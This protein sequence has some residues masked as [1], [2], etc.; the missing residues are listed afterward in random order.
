MI[1]L[2]LSIVL[3]IVFSFKSAFGQ[4]FIFAKK[5]VG[6]E[7]IISIHDISVNQKGEVAYVGTFNGT[8]DFDPSSSVYSLSSAGQEDMFFLKFDSLGDFSWAKRIG[9]TSYE[10]GTAIH[11]DNSDNIIT[12]GSFTGVVDFDPGSNVVNK[13]SSG[14]HDG[15]IS[16]YNKNGE[17]L[18]NRQLSSYNAQAAIHEIA[19]DYQNNVYIVGSYVDK[20]Y[21]GPN[22]NSDSLV[23]SGSEDVFFFKLDS[24]GNYL[25]KK[26][27]GGPYSDLAYSLEA[28][29]FNNIYLSGYFQFNCDFD[30]DTSVAVLYGGARTAYI[31]KYSSDGD[32]IWAKAIGS[33]GNNEIYSSK[34][35]PSGHIYSTGYFTG[36]QD[37]NPGVGV[38]ILSSNGQNDVFVLKL[39]TNG[40]FVWARKVGGSNYDLAN[41]LAIDSMENLFV[42]GR[43]KG[44]VD[45]DPDTSFYNLS[46]NGSNHAYTF[47]LDSAGF[48]KW[49]INTGGVYNSNG[50]SIDTD[51]KG[52]V[53]IHGYF[54]GDVDFDSGPDSTI[55]S[56]SSYSPFLLKLRQTTCL[57]PDFN[58]YYN[59]CDSFYWSQLDTTYYT[60]GIY[61]DTM[62]NIN[63]CDSVILL[64]LNIR[65]NYS[66]DT[67]FACNSYTWINGV[68]YFSN[69][70]VS[71]HTMQNIF[72]CDSTVFLN[73]TISNS[74][75]VVDSI[76]ACDSY[77]WIDGNTYY[78]NNTTAIDTLQTVNGCDS[79]V[80]LHLTINNSKS[81]TDSIIACDSYTWIDGNTYTSNNSTATHTLSAINGCDS[82]ISLDLTIHH[83]N[84]G[85]DAIT[86]CNSYTWIDG[87]TYTASSNLPTYTLT[88]SNGC[89]SVV[90]LQL[91]IENISDTSTSIVGATIS[92]NNT[93]ASYQWLNCDNSFSKIIGETGQSF[94]PTINGNYAVELTENTCI[95]TTTCV[96]INN[97]GIG[98]NASN[99]EVCIFPNPSSGSVT[100]NFDEKCNFDIKVYDLLGECIYQ[101]ANLF[102]K[103]YSFNL[104]VESGMYII[105]LSTKGKKIL[106]N[107][108]INK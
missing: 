42:T 21:F 87:N 107:L 24:N 68:T 15:F 9:G 38:S 43:F 80:T 82:I 11:V 85:V 36:I 32:Y 77:T 59:T 41:D 33:T 22:S 48:F 98:L 51:N 88:N 52:H 65:S 7:S 6:I 16:K 50:Y 73:L 53:Y 2:K 20:I 75:Y 27:F 46:T 13:T 67:I 29:D 100:L 40:Q 49:A 96:N 95:D 58:I 61:S 60:S 44:V 106:A 17:F 4:D 92:S 28:D 30:P 37:F 108:V 64:H 56:A 71:T 78:S 104:D 97:V 5:L 23:S 62:L 84:S 102:S 83:S 35:G 12:A 54:S 76:I 47:K 105:E 10:S 39:D 93:N 66:V 8:R 18:W 103:R 74:T 57:S 31:A 1:A 90:N 72:G 91:V 79:I 63:G 25:W 45:F 3:L 99:P 14:I 94:T 69:N 70:N 89:D 86:A 19:T 81:S 101:N 55:L 26:S 34:I